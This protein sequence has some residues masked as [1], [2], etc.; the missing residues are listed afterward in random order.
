MK[1]L[2]FSALG[3]LLLAFGLVWLIGQVRYHITPRHVKVMLL[4]LALRRIRVADIDSVS[5][6][7][8]QGL[9]E[10]WWSTLR[11]KHRVLVIRRKRGLFRNVVITPRNRYAFKFELEQAMEKSDAPEANLKKAPV[12]TD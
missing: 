9:A 2:V 3:L 4:G 1:I 12:F 5:K 10:N 7:R 11:P 6:H 8:S